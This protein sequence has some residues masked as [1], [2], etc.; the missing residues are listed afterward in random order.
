MTLLMGDT[1]CY[2]AQVDLGSD[3]LTSGPVEFDREITSTGVVDDGVYDDAALFHGPRFQVIRSLDSVSD[4]GAQ[5][6]LDGMDKMEWAGGP[7]ETDSAALDGCLQLALLWSSQAQGLRTVPMHVGEYIPY[8]NRGGKAFRCVLNI[9]DRNKQ[10]IT[11]DIHLLDEK[12]DPVA[13]LRQVEV[14][15]IPND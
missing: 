14:Y 2:K 15:A 8:R 4:D 12:G 1:P 7:W 11:S 9:T 13:D 6:T 10:R 5:A 3:Y